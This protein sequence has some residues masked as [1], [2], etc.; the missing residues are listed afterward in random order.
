MFMQKK[1]NPPLLVQQKTSKKTKN[2]QFLL[3]K[4][5]KGSET[6][7]LQLYSSFWYSQEYFT[8][9]TFEPQESILENLDLGQVKYNDD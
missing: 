9:K 8:Q 5:T 1:Q 4:I 7:T 2:F 3:E 6:G